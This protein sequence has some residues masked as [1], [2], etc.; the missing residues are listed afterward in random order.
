M[1]RGSGK[2]FDVVKGTITFAG[3]G[4]GNHRASDLPCCMWTVQ[5]R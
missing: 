4:G 1:I 3:N 5:L 2:Q